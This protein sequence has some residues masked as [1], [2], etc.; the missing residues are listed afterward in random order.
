LIA[1]GR[2]AIAVAVAVLAGLLLFVPAGAL[3]AGDLQ[4]SLNGL[5]RAAAWAVVWSLGAVLLAGNGHPQ[6]A[7]AAAVVAALGLGLAAAR[8]PVG[9][10]GVSLLAA[11]VVP[12]L[13]GSAPAGW[14][15][16]L[17]FG[18]LGPLA[19]TAAAFSGRQQGNEAIATGLV[20]GFLAAAGALPF[21]LHAVR[22]MQHALPEVAALVGAAFLPCA[23]AA[24]VAAE[25]ALS[26]AHAGQRIGLVLG[27]FGAATAIAG[28]VYAMA[29]NDWRGLALRT[30]PCEVGLALVGIAAF[31]IRGLQG[32][33]LTVALL[34]ITRPVL[35]YVDLLG[36]RR[37]AG[38]VLTALV[39][40]SAAGLPPTLGF[41]AR[42]LV[43][44]AATR[45]GPVVAVMAVTGVILELAA[46]A[47]VLRR[48]LAHPPGDQRPASP[49]SVV[50]L[51]I[52][53]S[54]ATLAG[55]VFPALL[56]GSV[57]QLGG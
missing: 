52:A 22:W 24:L 29:A 1:P 57:F 5:S 31:D 39:L 14:S 42:L 53:T 54:G 2:D 11:I 49:R 20:F 43:I 12:R 48:R 6:R 40:A 25:P 37:G 9:V 45:V 46:I 23:L 51:A 27:V 15:R 38:L 3:G 26:A 10:V 36:P 34:A 33:A 7:R 50:A 32:A 4:L 28:A 17:V 56:L 55:G 18:S 19:A 16:V 13:A 35:V 44:S 47:V 8:F 30:V 41:P 21:G